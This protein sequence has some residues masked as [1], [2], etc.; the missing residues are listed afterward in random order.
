MNNRSYEQDSVLT[1]RFTKNVSKDKP[2]VHDL[3]TN[4]RSFQ[5]ILNFASAIRNGGEATAQKAYRDSREEKP[6]IIRVI[7]DAGLSSQPDIPII[8]RAM[9]DAALQVKESLPP[10]DTGIVAFMAAHANLSRIVQDYLEE[11]QI[12]F[13]VQGRSSYQSWHVKQV[14]AYYR[15]IM[16]RYQDAEM[17][18]FLYNCVPQHVKRL[19]TIA[20]QN[21]Q[22]L[23]DVLVNDEVLHQLALPSEQEEILRQRLAIIQHYTSDSRFVE[24]WQAISNLPDG[25]LASIAEKTQEHEELASVRED[26]KQKKTVAEAMKH[27]SKYIA[28]VEEDRPDQPLVVTT[29]DNAKSQAF[30]TVFLLGAHLLNHRNNKK[31]WYVSVSRARNRFFFLVCE[32]CQETTRLLSWLPAEYYGELRL[33]DL[34][35]SKNSLTTII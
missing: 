3:D 18:Q 27:V 25:P 16:D 20:Q 9:V 17:I 13:S 35:S 26:L 29:V 30:D 10:T 34:E 23:F 15:L 1:W 33:S 21:G 12:P 14:L 4:Y 22:S 8:I 19:E 6:A 31:R 28:F 5:E 11:Q 2:Q 24:V 32:Q 7:C